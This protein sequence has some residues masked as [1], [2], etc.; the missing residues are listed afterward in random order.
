MKKNILWL[1]TL[2]S[3]SATAGVK[4]EV[5]IEIVSETL[6]QCKLTSNAM[7]AT[8]DV[9]GTLM[10]NNLEIADISACNKTISGKYKKVIR[11]YNSAR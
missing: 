4:R 11:F 2:I 1:F 8:N 10:A 3:F 9:E 7:F 6:D 5:K